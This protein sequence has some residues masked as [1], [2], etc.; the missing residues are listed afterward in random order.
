MVMTIITVMTFLCQNKDA[1]TVRKIFEL[2]KEGY[3]TY[4]LAKMFDLKG[5]KQVSDMLSRVTYI[6]KLKYNKEI[7]DGLHEPIVE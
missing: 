6:G 4:A 7:V 5:D 3:S 2:Y 1:E